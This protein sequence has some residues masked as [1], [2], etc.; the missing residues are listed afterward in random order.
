MLEG[1]RV[2]LRRSEPTDY[3]DIQR[4]QNDPEVFRWMDYEEPF[5][6]DDIRRSEERAR[7]EGHPFVIEADGKAIGRIGLNNFR[8]RDRMASLY[9]FIGEKGTRGKRYGIDAL[10]TLLRYGFDTLNL[11]KIELWAL[12]DNERALQL[13]KS[14]GFH[15]DARLP[16]RSFHDG[17]YLDHVVMSI[18]R[19]DFERSRERLGY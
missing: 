3:A 11:R 10:M 5:S 4:W 17:E 18:D 6:L 19:E 13:Y 14:A 12:G 15:E 8:K 1:K 2:T 16:S 9:V 7:E